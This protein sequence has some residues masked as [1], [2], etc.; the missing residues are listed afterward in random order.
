[1]STARVLLK[2]GDSTYRFLT[3]TAGS[4]GSL[5]VLLDRKPRVPQ[6]FMK[7]D[8]T[9]KFVPQPAHS[10]K[11]VP[12][13]KFSLHT[14]GEI[15]RYLHG[16]LCN[17]IYVE[18]LLAVT[19]SF[20]FGFLSLPRP[21]RLDVADMDQ[22]RDDVCVT[23]EVPEDVRTTFA[24]LI[25]PKKKISP[26]PA[27]SID[28]ELYSLGLMLSPLPVNLTEAQS[29]H[30]LHG[31]ARI[32]LFDRR[33]SSSS[34]AELSFHQSVHGTDRLVF[35]EDSGAYVVMASVPM[36]AAP[37]LNVTFSRPDLQA[38]VCK[39]D[40]RDQPVHK[41]RFW[42]RD[43]GGR[44]KRDDLRPYIVAVTFDAEL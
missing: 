43:S 44:N 20:P 42:I 3:L 38:E 11:A 8:E 16:K 2:H 37:K 12:S 34:Q 22:L 4:D 26:S 23:L 13:T 6:Q 27:I 30:F 28:Y 14:S 1:M 31:M 35:R 18:P 40:K 15:R 24:L 17:V 21:S 19:R 9:G 29:D 7:L 36:R 10:S 39:Y 32:G 41:V 33:Q 5:Y 25:G